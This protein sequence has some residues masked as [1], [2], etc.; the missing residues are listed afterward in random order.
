MSFNEKDLFDCVNETLDKEQ[1]D[2]YTFNVFI[3]KYKKHI[4]NNFLNTLKNEKENYLKNGH[5]DIVKGLNVAISIIAKG[6]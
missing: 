5:H 1:L 4:A 3:N 6:E 2:F